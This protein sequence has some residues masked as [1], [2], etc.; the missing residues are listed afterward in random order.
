MPFAFTIYANMSA[1]FLDDGTA[2]GEAEASALH[3]IIEFNE[4]VE[5]AGLFL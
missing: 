2:D 1:T 4:T 3:K 5:D